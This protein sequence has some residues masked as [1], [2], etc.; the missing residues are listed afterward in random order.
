MDNVIITWDEKYATKIDIIDK[1][2]LKLVNLT[3]EL[4]S[5]CLARN[6][7]LTSA[8]KNAM[9]SMVDYV[10][11]H[12]NAEN[13]L[14]S[15]IEYPE[16]K[17]HKKM[18]DVL[19]QKILDAVKEYNDG[20]VFVPNNFV[21]TLVDWVF[22]HIAFYDKQYAFFAAERIKTGALSLDKL[23]EIEKSIA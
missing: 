10:K 19:I 18:H 6:G 14:L 17:N 21:R 3:N 16:C 20:K 4:Y 22:S 12:F 15:A 2:H 5:A 23:K 11:F 1:Q 7:E 9:S 13:K 8:F